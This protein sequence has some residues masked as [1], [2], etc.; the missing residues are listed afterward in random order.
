MNKAPRAILQ[1]CHGYYGPFTDCARQYARLFRDTPYKVVTVQL[2]GAPDEKVAQGLASDEVIFL[3]YRSSEIR[4][5][6]LK[7]IRDI[8]RIAA[9]RDFAFCIAHRFKS[10]YTALFATDLMVLGVHHHFGDYRRLS[11]RLCA[12]VFKKRL[13]LLGV[14]NALRDDM[15]AA[16]PGWTPSHIETLYNRIDIAAAQAALLPR[17]TARAALGLPL[18][19]W[20]VGNV[21]RL[22]SD[23]DQ[24]TL[25]R[26]FA[27]ALPGLPPGSLLAIMGSGP[28]EEALKALAAELGIR[29]SVRFLGQINEGRRYFRAF[30]VFALSSGWETFGMVFLEALIARLPVVCCDS[31]GGREVVEGI[32]DLFPFGD[33]DALAR[34]LVRLSEWRETEDYVMRVDA[35]LQQRFSD[36]AAAEAF[37]RLPMLAQYK[38]P[39]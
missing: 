35:H 11:R 33:A 7:A 25:I 32:G 20:V 38:P 16:L 27:K 14:S 12:N 26:A 1:V 4:N 30:D 6:K 15:R 10:I 22:H 3:N 39:C 9:S 8:R 23:K 31:G 21:G 5:L 36:E 2:I 19:G 17:E 13:R 18:Q 34:V 28:L 37:W 29:E 24:A